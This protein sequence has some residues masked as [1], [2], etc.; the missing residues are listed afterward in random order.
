MGEYLLDSRTFTFQ[1]FWGA[2]L[3]VAQLIADQ[4]FLFAML[5]EQNFSDDWLCGFRSGKIY[6]DSR[7]RV[8]RFSSSTCRRMEPRT[9]L[10]RRGAGANDLS[11]RA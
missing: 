3:L 1:F 10:E 9:A 11:G 8:D 5:T 4:L 6:F 2:L 7:E